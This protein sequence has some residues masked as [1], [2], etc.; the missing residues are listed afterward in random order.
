MQRI[1]LFVSSTPTSYLWDIC[2]KTIDGK[3]GS[4]SSFTRE[5][6]RK[7]QDFEKKEMMSNS[8]Q[9]RKE[10]SFDDLQSCVFGNLSMLTQSNEPCTMAY[11]TQ[12]DRQVLYILWWT[13]QMAFKY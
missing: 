8:N 6:G 7:L 13:C 10:I 3:T 2:Y 1:D 9:L 11:H 12:Y 4:P 5:I